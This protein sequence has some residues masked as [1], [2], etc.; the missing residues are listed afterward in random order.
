MLTLSVR[1]VML[2]N[3]TPPFPLSLEKLALCEVELLLRERH[4]LPERHQPLELGEERIVVLAC[5]VARRP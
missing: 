3:C 1:W 5:L 2:P 4:R